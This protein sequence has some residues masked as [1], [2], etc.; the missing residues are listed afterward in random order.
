LG[1]EV[2]LEP[3]QEDLA[4][5]LLVIH[6]DGRGLLVLLREDDAQGVGVLPTKRV[7]VVPNGDDIA[8]TQ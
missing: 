8:C 1:G 2:P 5:V 3:T 6:I 4:C 7:V